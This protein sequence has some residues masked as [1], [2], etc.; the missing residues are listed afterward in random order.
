[1]GV[2]GCKTN[3]KSLL[4]ETKEVPPCPHPDSDPHIIM[5]FGV[6]RLL[7]MQNKMLPNLEYG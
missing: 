4:A 6:D 2:H 3:I 1:M 7:Q 5:R